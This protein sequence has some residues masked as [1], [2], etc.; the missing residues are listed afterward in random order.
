VAAWTVL[1]ILHQKLSQF[2][3]AEKDYQTAL[4]L[5]PNAAIAANNLAWLYCEQGG[6][7]DKALELARRAREVLPKVA[8]VSDTL[9]WVY[10]KRQLFDSAIPLLQE[11][12]REQ[13]KDAQFRFHLAASL[14]GAGKKVEA[15]EELGTALKLDAS[16]RQD[17]DY[18]RIFG[19]L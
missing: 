17:A 4:A 1:G 2:K 15:Q 3:L 12:V 11:A 13:P 10:Y 19:R 7:M 18:Q 8:T 9:A 5:D 14:L 16:L 6:D